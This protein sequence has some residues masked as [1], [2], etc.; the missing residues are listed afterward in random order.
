MTPIAD[1]FG[2][3]LDGCRAGDERSFAQLWRRFNAPLH[4]YLRVVASSSDIEDIASITWIEV[5][6]GL[7]RFSGGEQEFRAWLFT[8]ARL[9]LLDRRR[10]ESRRIRT[11]GSDDPLEVVDEAADPQLMSEAAAATEAAIAA[12]GNLPAD[13]AEVLALRVIAG[14]DVAD[15]AEITGK[16]PGTVRVLAHRAVKRLAAQIEVDDSGGLVASPAPGDG[17]GDVT[18]R[19]PAEELAGVSDGSPV[20]SGNGGGPDGA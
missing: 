10:Q 2:R 3:L 1:E 18:A 12:I 5:V 6:R 16:K 19:Q 7:E 17:P 20:D 4:R 9:R 13:Q 11:V 14:F 8:I 15:V